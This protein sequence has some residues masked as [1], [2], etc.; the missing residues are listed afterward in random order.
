MRR[1]IRDIIWCR[2]ALNKT[3]TRGYTAAR[4]EYI[5]AHWKKA[6]EKPPQAEHW[7]FLNRLMGRKS[8]SRS[9]P[10]CSPDALNDAFIRKVDRI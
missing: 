3:A 4:R 8:K 6:G 2:N 1:R 5:A 9:E 10:D 7:R